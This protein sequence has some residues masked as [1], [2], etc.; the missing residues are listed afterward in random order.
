MNR[1]AVGRWKRYERE[2]APL[3]AALE[4]EGVAVQ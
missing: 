3:R 2:L 4:R 1:D